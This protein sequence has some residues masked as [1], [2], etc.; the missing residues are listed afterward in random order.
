MVT[1]TMFANQ[2]CCRV[3]VCPPVIT[4]FSVLARNMMIDVPYVE[5]LTI[6]FVVDALQSS[7]N[8]ICFN[9]CGKCCDRQSVSLPPE[10]VHTSRYESDTTLLKMAI[11]LQCIY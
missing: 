1:L 6:R 9:A 7:Q 5:R 3:S 10:S 4:L 2:R 8:I 11:C